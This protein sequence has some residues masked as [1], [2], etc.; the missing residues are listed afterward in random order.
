MTTLSLLCWRRALPVLLVLALAA[1]CSRRGQAPEEFPPVHLGTTRDEV[2][3]QVLGGRTRV[4]LDTPQ[5]L[6]IV[7]RDSRVAEEVFFFYDGR[8]AAWTLRFTRTSSRGSFDYASR[9]FDMAFGAPLEKSDNGL[10]LTSRWK[11]PQEHGLVV[12]SGYVADRT[13]RA[14]LMVRVE[15]PSV[16]RGLYR[17]MRREE[18]GRS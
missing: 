1:G 11:L 12:L 15:D 2:R 17:Q 18:S 13:G 8:L 9:R 4:L 7:D 6:R 10:V 16:L 14:P 3:D 5:T